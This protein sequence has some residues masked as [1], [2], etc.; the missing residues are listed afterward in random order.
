ML[1]FL[2]SP[3][4]KLDEVRPA[5][6]Q[7]QGEPHF[8]QESAALMDVLRP[9]SPPALESLMKISDKLALLNAE[10]Y[11][12]FTT[13][14]TEH[15]AKPAIFLF[16]GDAY[17][18]L[19]AYDLSNTALDYV[20]NHLMILSGL[21]GAVKSLDWIAPYRLEMGTAL[22]NPRGKNLYEFWGSRIT[23]YLNQIIAEKGITTVINL[24]SHEYF[25]AVDPK[26]LT[27]PV[28]TPIFKDYKNGQYKTISF[29]AKKARGAMV[30]YAAE[31]NVTSPDDLK[32]FDLL[33]YAFKGAAQNHPSEWLFYKD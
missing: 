26:A 17:E 23:D 27:V 19:N 13:P 15:N 4:K 18:S 11:S 22:T 7:G 16:N 29:N 20:Q 32:A 3:A 24:A 12:N 10:R 8:I 1:L 6:V 14:L 2:L 33:G 5:P 9:L 31:Q 25:S 21:Y 28:I 30:R